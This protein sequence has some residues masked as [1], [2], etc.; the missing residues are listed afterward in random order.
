MGQISEDLGAYVPGHVLEHKGVEYGFYHLTLADLATFEKGN[1]RSK[2]DVLHEM[3][4][5][6]GQQEYLK[7]LDQLTER[8][9][10]NEFS[11]HVDQSFC[12]KLEGIS[13]L[14]RLI[15]KK[16]PE[17][18]IAALIRD[19]LHDVRRLMQLVIRES[20]GAAVKEPEKEAE[21]PNAPAAGTPTQ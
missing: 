20:F 18:A 9:H 17:A 7:R 4:E 11:L 3:R 6:Y 16:T 1:F 15:L 13:L 14:L 2:K 12:Q 19:R 8:Y 10:R 21:S 5:D